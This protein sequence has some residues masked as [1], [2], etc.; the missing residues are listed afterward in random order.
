[1]EEPEVGRR[2]IL[3]WIFDKW[4]RGMDKIDLVKVMNLGVPQNAGVS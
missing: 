2:I 4:D 1:M 3:K